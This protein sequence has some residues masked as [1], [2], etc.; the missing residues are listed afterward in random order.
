MG[1]TIGSMLLEQEWKESDVSMTIFARRL[2]SHRVTV[3]RWIRGDST[4]GT[5]KVL[6]M[7][8]RMGIPAPSWSQ[9]LKEES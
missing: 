6:L 8:E 2:G 1:R 5:Q 7:Q 3:F 4:P 9:P